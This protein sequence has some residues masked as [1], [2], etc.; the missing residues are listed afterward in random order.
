MLLSN[1]Q[2]LGA[3]LALIFFTLLACS[4]GASH[5]EKARDAAAKGE[6]ETAFQ[7]YE[8]AIQEEGAKPADKFSA[9]TERAKLYLEQDNV[10]AALADYETALGLT[11]EDGSPAGNFNTIRMERAE[12]YVTLED[13]EA[14]VADLDQ[15]LAEQPDNYEALAR[16]GY[17]QLQLRN[18]EQ[19]IADLKASLQGN[20]AAASADL[21][22][23]QNLINAYYDLAE[24]MRDLG[25]YP[26]S[27]QYY[28]EA[29]TLAEDQD[30]RAE[31]LAARAFVYSELKDSE[32]AL[33]DLNEALA[34]DPNMA[35]AYAYRSYVYGDQEQY[36]AAIADA[37][38]A[39]ELGAD[40]EPDRLASILH[41]RAL[42]YLF[43]DQYEQAIA[44]ATESI[45]LAGADSADAARTYNIRS[46]SYRA[47]GDYPQ[48]IADA[49]QAIELGAT[50]VVAL[51]GFYRSRAFA[52][53]L[54]QDLPNARADIEAALSLDGEKPRSD[55]LD[56]LGQI[57]LQQGEYE[58]AIES[59]QK[60]LAI[61]PD[62]AW[63]HSGLGDV[64]YEL[65]DLASAETEY[66]AAVSL[67]PAVAVF[68]EN[69]G[70]VLRL[71]ERFDEAIES[72][73]Q[74]L[75]LDD[76]RP[77]SWLGRG[78]AY[79]NLRRDAEAI[80]DL[81]TVLT[82]E[83]SAEVVEAVEGILAEIRP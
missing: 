81:E 9:L 3:V 37:N 2:K 13:W 70:L 57:Q 63:L 80:P 25:E 29:L 31:I 50:D 21:D 27:I 72:Y 68:H 17:A 18:F 42:A 23:K 62:D 82:F 15:V 73:S 38:K 54:N 14:V 11:N 79:Y 51:S 26:D 45:T 65:E 35:L 66:R 44:D 61:T 49:T 59:Y 33:A 8:Q 12:I 34:L 41:A 32:K 58:A 52:H 10:E 40:L 77:Y 6:I 74:A 46:Q 20:V 43:L 16:R 28:S 56:L 5:L 67:D 48:A 36:E 76:Q 47:I 71:T 24:A 64:H 53:Y 22:S 83:T 4:L 75:A 69:L 60:A 55:D 19:A 30:D 39:V 7:E 78:L 1:R